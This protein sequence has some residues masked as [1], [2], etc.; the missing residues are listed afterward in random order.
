MCVFL[1][2]DKTCHLLA[3]RLSACVSCSLC[4]A[5]KFRLNLG[6]NALF[7]EPENRGAE[8]NQV[9]CICDWRWAVSGHRRNQEQ[10]VWLKGGAIS[11]LVC[12]LSIF[13][14]CFWDFCGEHG[15]S[16]SP[17][18]LNIYLYTQIILSPAAL[19]CSLTVLNSVIQT[20]CIDKASNNLG[21]QKTQI[22]T[23]TEGLCP[24]HGPQCGWDSR[25]VL[26]VWPFHCLR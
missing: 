8:L 14:L 13:I 3:W 11:E 18:A 23:R 17:A 19:A 25:S 9:W 24:V 6:A 1:L 26:L 15:R 10:C 21:K 20:R 22:W 2:L 12:L 7:H 16:L 4:R 5:V